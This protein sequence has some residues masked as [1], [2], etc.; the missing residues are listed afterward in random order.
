MLLDWIIPTKSGSKKRT[1]LQAEWNKISP[2]EKYIKAQGS[3]LWSQEQ[4]IK[5]PEGE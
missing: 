3:A 1:G 4:L 5:F 2:K